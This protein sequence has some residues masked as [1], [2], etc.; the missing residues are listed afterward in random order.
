MTTSYDTRTVPTCPASQHAHALGLPVVAVTPGE[1]LGLAASGDPLIVHTVD[2]DEVLLRL[3]TIDEA[4]R[5]HREAVAS[6]GIDGLPTLNS[7]QAERLVR[8]LD[9]R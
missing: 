9:P 5:F 4:L 6:I 2:G 1:L 7:D 3:P 8:P